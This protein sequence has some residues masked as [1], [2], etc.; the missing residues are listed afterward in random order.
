MAEGR[1]TKG[2]EGIFTGKKPD[3]VRPSENVQKAAEVIQRRIPNANKLDEFQLNNSIKGEIE[4]ISGQ[5]KPQLQEVRFEP[6]QFSKAEKEWQ[7]IKKTQSNTPEFLNSPG[8]IRVQE[9]FENFLNEAKK[10]V[11]GTD[12]K[13]RQK[14]LDDI[15]EIRK[16]YDDSIPDR[17]KQATEQSPE[18][19]QLQRE[20]WL[21]NR[22]ILNDLIN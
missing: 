9:N 2:A 14:S 12:G 5:L 4:N 21:E 3:I 18:F 11:K 16:R 15:W 8:S 10:P 13:F 7:A 1:V 19:A 6:A 20:M 22:R 17:V